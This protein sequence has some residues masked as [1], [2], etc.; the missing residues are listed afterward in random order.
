MYYD[1]PRG[2]KDLVLGIRALQ[3]VSSVQDQH[4]EH[5]IVAVLTFSKFAPVYDLCFVMR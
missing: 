1:L 2:W 5:T 3:L 4:I